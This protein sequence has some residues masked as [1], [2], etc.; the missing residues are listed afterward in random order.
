MR[1]YLTY[2]AERP[3][4]PEEPDRRER[5]LAIARVFLAASVFIAAFFTPSDS[6]ESLRS[7]LFAG[8]VIF[9]VA[10]L[11]L[12]RTRGGGRTRMTVVVHAIDLSAAAGGRC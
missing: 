7:L 11:I 1:R 9:A 12:L 8:Y 4:S 3:S 5:S 10:V 6:P 2:G